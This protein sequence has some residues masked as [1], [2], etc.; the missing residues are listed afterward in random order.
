MSRMVGA[1]ALSLALA[2]ATP[3]F[4]AGLSGGG[5]MHVAG[6]GSMHID[7]VGRAMHVGGLGDGGGTHVGGAQA[8]VGDGSVSGGNFTGRVGGQFAHQADITAITTSTTGMAALL[9][10]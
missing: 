1:A 3:A 5:G 6:G 7:G 9:R 2:V 8:S 4:A 10:G